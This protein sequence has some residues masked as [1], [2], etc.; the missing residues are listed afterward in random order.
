MFVVLLLAAGGAARASDIYNPVFVPI[1]APDGCLP[2]GT[3][4]DDMPYASTVPN[5][6]YNLVVRYLGADAVSQPAAS[7]VRFVGVGHGEAGEPI[8]P[9]ET[10]LSR[11]PSTSATGASAFARTC[12][13]AAFLVSSFATPFGIIVGG[14]QHAAYEYK[15]AE[16]GERHGGNGSGPRAAAPFATASSDLMVQ[17][18]LAAPWFLAADRADAPGSPIAQL[19]IVFYLQ[20]RQSG[21]EIAYVVLAYEPRASEI[22]SEFVGCD[23]S[24]SPCIP[25]VSTR[26]LRALHNADG[27]TRPLRY[28]TL[29]PYSAEAQNTTWDQRRFFRSHITR[30]NLLAALDVADTYRAANGQPAMPRNL[31]AYLLTKLAVLAET[32]NAKRPGAPDSDVDARDNVSF[33]ATAFGLGAWETR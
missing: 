18:Y 5:G 11:A 22:N 13:G 25:F 16:W 6:Q 24:A 29:S 2:G 8:E 14:G 28:S 26:F 10:R 27:S 32:S 4:V 17:A 31:D 3:Y 33:G 30:A 19:S 20:H 7:F 1:L 23:V 9:Q 21:D 15:W 12:R